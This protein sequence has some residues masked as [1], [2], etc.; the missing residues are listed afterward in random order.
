MSVAQKGIPRVT[1]MGRACV[2]VALLVPMLAQP[3]WASGAVFNVDSTTDA[4]DLVH[5]DGFCAT[6]AAECT[7]RAATQEA[8]ALAGSDTIEIP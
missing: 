6:A 8:N 1:R 4:V 3:L 5:G 7:L 2:L